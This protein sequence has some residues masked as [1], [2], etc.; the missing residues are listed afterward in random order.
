MGREDCIEGRAR[1]CLLLPSQQ[2]VGVSK[3][4]LH[5]K[6]PATKPDRLSLILRV[7]V[8]KEKTNS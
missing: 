7:H 5:I 8:R 6:V 3:I 1:T 4:V 2:E